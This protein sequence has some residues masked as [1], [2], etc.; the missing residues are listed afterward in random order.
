MSFAMKMSFIQEAASA[1]LY[2]TPSIV[3][4]RDDADL[5]FS[6]DNLGFMGALEDAVTLTAKVVGGEIV[7]VQAG[8][9]A[10]EVFCDNTTCHDTFVWL[11]MEDIEL[12]SF[13]D[14]DFVLEPVAYLSQSF[15]IH[16]FSKSAVNDV[17]D[18]IAVTSTSTELGYLTVVVDPVPNQP[19]INVSNRTVTGEEELPFSMFVLGAWSPDQDGSEIIEVGLSIPATLVDELWIDNEESQL[20]NKSVAREDIILVSRAQSTFETGIHNITILPAA[21]FSGNFDFVIFVRSIEQSTNES[22]STDVTIDVNIHAMQVAVPANLTLVTLN[23]TVEEGQPV[24]LRAIVSNQLVHLHYRLV[25][26]FPIDFISGIGNDEECDKSDAD[27]VCSIVLA[28]AF[29]VSDNF[30]TVVELEIDPNATDLSEILECRTHRER[31][32]L[33]GAEESLTLTVLPVAEAPKFTIDQNDVAIA[34]NALLSVQVTNLA[35]QDLDGSETLAAII[36]C[37]SMNWIYTSTNEGMRR[38][39][40]AGRYPLDLLQA[41]HHSDTSI[42]TV[43]LE[44]RQYFSGTINCS[45]VATAIDV[46]AVGVARDVY[47]V[48]FVTTVTPVPTTPT[49]STTE[50]FFTIKE[51]GT[52]LTDAV[53]ASL[54]DRDGSEVLYLKVDFGMSMVHI[55]AVDWS[56]IGSGAVTLV[57]DGSTVVVTTTALDMVGQLAVQATVGFSGV[58]SWTVAAYSVEKSLGVSYPSNLSV[59]EMKAK[60]TPICHVPAVTMLPTA[61]FTRPL[62]PLELNLTVSTPDRDG[63]EEVQAIV[64]VNVGAVTAILDE[65]GQTL[66]SDNDTIGDALQYHVSPLDGDA[67]YLLNARLFFVPQA[68]FVGI[69]TI[70][71]SAWATEYENG[72]SKSATLSVTVLVLPVDPVMSATATMYSYESAVVHVPFTRFDIGAEVV[73]REHLLLYLPDASQID[74]VYAGLYRADQIVMP[75]NTVGVYSI[76]YEKRGGIM[77]RPKAFAVGFVDIRFVL[78]TVPFELTSGDILFDTVDDGIQVVSVSLLILPVLVDSTKYL[79][80]SASSDVVSSNKPI[81]ARIE[82]SSVFDDRGVSAAGGITPSLLTTQSSPIVTLATTSALVID[83]TSTQDRFFNSFTAD[84]TDVVDVWFLFRFPNGYTDTF[85][86]RVILVTQDVAGQSSS[87]WSLDTTCQLVAEAAGGRLHHGV[88]GGVFVLPDDG[89]IQF[90]LADLGITA[91]L[92]D[93]TRVVLELPQNQ[94]DAVL[95]DNSTMTSVTCDETMRCVYVVADADTVACTG[96]SARCPLLGALTVMPRKYL[97]QTFTFRV[98]VTNREG[99]ADDLFAVSSSFVTSKGYSANVLPVPNTPLMTFDTTNVT[100]VEELPFAFM[101]M[102]AWTPDADGSEVIEV[103]MMMD[104]SLLQSVSVNESTA[105]L[106]STAGSALLIL[107]RDAGVSRIGQTSI[108]MLPRLDFNGGFAVTMFV[109][110]LELSTG[111]I[112]QVNQTVSVT[113]LAMPVVT[114]PRIDVSV[115][116]LTVLEDNPWSVSLRVTPSSGGLRYVF[117]VF[118]PGASVALIEDTNGTA[119]ASQGSQSSPQSLCV[120]PTSSM[121]QPVS[122]T[123]TVTLSMRIWPVKKLSSRF[124]VSI[125]VLALTSDILDALFKSTC[126]QQSRSVDEIL[127][128]RSNRERKSLLSVDKALSLTVSPVAEAPRIVLSS[129]VVIVNENDQV[130]LSIRSITLQ[131]LDGSEQITVALS[132]AALLWDAVTVGN[133][134]S[135]FGPALN[136]TLAQLTAPSLT[137]I[138]NLQVSLRPKMYFSGSISCSVVATAIDV[139]PVGTARDVFQ[140][141]FTATVNAV[142]TTPVLS[143]PRTMFSI[144]EDGLVVTDPVS[145][146][147]VDRDS[148]ESLYVVFDFG[149]SMPVIS[150]AEWL[151][152]SPSDL[153]VT[154]VKTGSA[155]IIYSDSSLDISGRLSV[156]PVVGFSGNVAWQASAFSAEKSFKLSPAALWTTATLAGKSSAVV[157]SFSVVVSPICHTPQVL[158]TPTSAVSRPLVPILMNISALTADQDG[159]EVLS[160]QVV[161]N[162]TAVLQ[163]RDYNDGSVWVPS[164]TVQLVDTFMVGPAADKPVFTIQRWLSIVPRAEFTGYFTVNLTV[165]SLE[166]ETGE[167]KSASVALLVMIL[168]ADPVVSS[169]AIVNV[170]ENEMVR[171]PFSR[172]D[173]NQEVMTRDNVLLY[174][175]DGSMVSD[176][177]VGFSRLQ[178]SS[179][180]LGS[181]RFYSIPYE[182]RNLVFLRP[183]QYFVGFLEVYFILST[184]KIPIQTDSTYADVNDGIT[185]QSSQV[186]TIPVPVEVVTESEQ[187]RSFKCS[188]ERTIEVLDFQN[189]SIPL[190]NLSFVGSL[191]DISFIR[192]EYAP[193]AVDGVDVPSVT[194]RARGA[195]PNYDADVYDT[196]APADFSCVQG[197]NPVCSFDGQINVMPHLYLAQSFKMTVK[198]WFLMPA[199]D[200]SFVTNSQALA[201]QHYA[202][203][204]KPA[205]NPPYLVLSALVINGAE[206]TESSFLIAS[207]GTPDQ[208]GSE[209]IE[210]SIRF[211][212]SMVR[213]VKL[214]SQQLPIR[215][216]ENSTTGM[217]VVVG[218]DAMQYVVNALSIAVTPSLNLG[219]ISFQMTVQVVS[220]ETSTRETAQFSQVITLNIGAVADPPVLIVA[221]RDVTTAQGSMTQISVNS[222]ELVDKDGSETLVVGIQ[223]AGGLFDRV[224]VNMNNSLLDGS[225]GIFVATPPSQLPFT[226]EVYPNKG[227]FGTTTFQ[228]FATSA[229]LTNGNQSTSVVTVQLTVSPLADVPVIEVEDTRGRL[230]DWVSVGIVNITVPN[231]LKEAATQLSAYLVPD[232]TRAQFQMMQ[233]STIVQPQTRVAVSSSPSYEVLMDYE[234][235]PVAVK[236][237]DPVG[238]LTFDLVVIT[239]VQSSNSTS[240]S[241]ESLTVSFAGVVFTPPSLSLTEGDVRQLSLQMLSAPLGTV[242]LSLTSSIPAK[243]VP[244]PPEVTFSM[245]DWSTT[246][247]VRIT[248]L[249]NYLDDPDASGVLTSVVTST[250][251]MYSGMNL[252]AFPIVVVNDDFSNV[253]AFQGVVTSRP[254]VV[255]SERRILSDVFSL[256][257]TAEPTADVT[258]SL[259]LASGDFLVV[260]PLQLFFTSTNWNVSQLVS[261]SADDNGIQDGGGRVGHIGYAVSSVDPLY[262]GKAIPPLDVNIVETSDTTPPPKMTSA[263][264]LN[265]AVGLTVTFDRPIDRSDFAATTFPCDLIFDVPWR[266]FGNGTSCTWLAGDSSIRFVFGRGATV[267]PGQGLGLKGGLLRASPTAQLRSAQTSVAITPPDIIPQPSAMVSGATSLGVCDDLSLDGSSSTGSGG[268]T[269]SFRWFLVGSINATTSVAD[270]QAMLL[271]AIVTNNATMVIPG[272]ML[273]PDATYQFVLQASNFF[274][275]ASNSSV[276][277]VKKSGLPLPVVSIKGGNVQQ[278]YRAKEL[279]ISA[280]ADNPRCSVPSADGGGASSVDMSFRWSQ[281]QGDLT[282]QA[283][284]STS[285]NPRVLKLPPRTLNIGTKYIFQIFVSMVSNP[286]IANSATVELTVL[287]SPLSAQVLG[288]DREWGTTQNLTLDATQSLD[289]D[290]SSVPMQYQWNCSQFNNETLQY[291]LGCLTVNSTKLVLEPIGKTL[292]PASTMMAD[293][294]YKFSAIVSKDSRTSSTS[295]K[296]LFK[297]GSIPQVS[298]A[299]LSSSRV[300]VN[301][302]VMLQAS[303][304]SSVPLQKTLWSLVGSNAGLEA[305]LFAVPAS[306]TTMVLAQNAMIPGATY[307]FQ[308]VAVDVNGQNSTAS[309]IVTANSPPTSGELVVSPTSGIALADKFVLSSLN[310]V[311]ED[312]P[313]KY[314]YKFIKGVE[315]DESVEIVMGAASLEP[316]LSTIFPVGAGEASIITVVAYVMDALGA[317]T[318]TTAEIT[319]KEQNFANSTARDAYL[320]SMA[321]DVLAQAMTGDPSKVM[322]VISALGD[323]IA[324]KEAISTVAPNDV[325]KACPKANNAQCN[326]KGNCL[327]SPV[328]CPATDV[329]CVVTCQ[330]LPNYFGDNCALTKAQYEAKQAAVSGL[331]GA[332]A[333]SVKSIDI[334]DASA[335]EQSAGGILSLTKSAS[336]LGESAQNAAVNFVDNI[337]SAQL[338][339]SAA[340]AVGNT[341]SNILDAEVNRAV[342]AIAPAAASHA[343]RLTANDSATTSNTSTSSTNATDEKAMQ[344]LAAVEKIKGTIGKFGTALLASSLP[345]EKPVSFVSKNMKLVGARD[346]PT[347]FEGKQVKVPLTAAEIAANFTPPSCTIPM[348][349]AQHIQAQRRRRRLTTGDETDEEAPVDVHSA[350]FVK[351]PYAFSGATVNSP[352]MSIKVHEGEGEVPVNDLAQPFQIFMRNTGKVTAIV[353]GVN[354]TTHSDVVN[355][356]TLRVS[357]YL[358]C[359]GFDQPV[360][361]EVCNGTSGYRSRA[362]CP[363]RTP[364]CQYWNTTLNNWDTTGCTA[365]GTTPDG[366]YTICNCTHLTDFA[367]DVEQ[368]LAVLSAHFDRVMTHTVTAADIKRNVALII[369]MALFFILFIIAFFYVSR[370]DHADRIRQMREN[371][372]RIQEAQKVNV[373][374]LF[375]EPEYVRAVGYRAKA[376]AV[377]ASFWKGLKEE[378]KLLSIAFKYDEYFSRPQR[379]TIIFTVIMSHMFTN[380]LLYANKTTGAKTV[381]GAVVCGVVS[382]LCMMPVT[383]AFV[384]MFKKAGRKRNYVLRY[385]VE[386]SEGNVAHVE[387]DAYGK[388]REYSPIEVCKMDM[389]AIA[390]CVEVRRIKRFVRDFKKRGLD[391]RVG[392]VCRGL[393]LAI[394]NRD[395]DEDPPVTNAHDEDV[396]Q[397]VLHQI[398]TRI[399][400]RAKSLQ[401]GGAAA[402]AARRSKSVFGLFGARS[403]R[404]LMEMLER[405]GGESMISSMLAFDPLSLTASTGAKIAEVCEALSQYANEEEEYDSDDDDDDDVDVVLT[406]KD[407]LDKCHECCKL[408]Q[409]S[410]RAMMHKAKVELQRTETQLRK[411]EHAIGSQFDR[412]LTELGVITEALAIG[413]RRKTTDTINGVATMAREARRKTSRRMRKQSEVPKVD[414]RLSVTI[415]KEKKSVLNANRAVLKEKRNAVKRAQ[416]MT[417]DEQKRLRKEADRELAKVTMGLV[418]IAKMKKKLQLYLEAKEKQRIDALPW[419]ERHA[420]ELEK[421]QLKKIKGVSRLLYNQFLRRQP[422]KVAKPIFP[423]WVVYIS[424]AISIV[425]CCWSAYFVMMFGFSLTEENTSTLWIGSLLAGLAMTH[426]VS[427]PAKIF[428]KMGLMP[429]VA[430]GILADTGVFDLGSEGLALAAAAALGS[431]GVAQVIAKNDSRLK[432]KMRT[433]KLVPTTEEEALEAIAGRLPA[434]VEE[435][436]DPV[437]PPV[438]DDLAKLEVEK[439]KEEI[440]PKLAIH[441]R[442]PPIP[443][444]V[445]SPATSPRPI[446]HLPSRKPISIPPVG[447]KRS[448]RVAVEVT[449]PVGE[450]P[451]PVHE[452]PPLPVTQVAMPEVPPLPV[453]QL[454]EQPR[455]VDKSVVVEKP[456]T[457]EKPLR[458]PRV[459]RPARS[460]VYE[461]PAAP[462]AQPEMTVCECGDTMPADTLLEH[463]TETC[464][465][466]L[467]QCRAGCGMFVQARSL[468]GHELSQCRLV[469]CSCGKM[470][471]TKSLEQHQQRECRNK[472]ISC[473]LECGQRFP[474]HHR[475]RHERHECAMRKTSCPQ[476]GISCM[477]MDMERHMKGECQLHQASTKVTSAMRAFAPQPQVQPVEAQPVQAPQPEATQAPVVSQPKL[478]VSAI[479]G[480]MRPPAGPPP[481]RALPRAPP[482]PAGP[483]RGPLAGSAVG[484]AASAA[485]A[486]HDLPTTPDKEKVQK[487]RERLLARKHPNLQVSTTSEAEEKA[488]APTGADAAQVVPTEEKPVTPSVAAARPSGGAV[489]PTNAGA[490]T[491]RFMM[492]PPRGQP[493]VRPPVRPVMRPPPMAPSGT[494]PS[495]AQA[496]IAMSPSSRRS[497]LMRGPGLAVIAPKAP[498]VESPREDEV[499]AAALARPS[500]TIEVE[501]TSAAPEAAAVPGVQV[502]RSPMRASMRGPPQAAVNPESKPRV[503]PPTSVAENVNEIAKL[504]FDNETAEEDKI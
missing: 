269:L 11:E 370:W 55:A 102:G 39:G 315:T 300:N 173:I 151:S 84:T 342:P 56:P 109:R 131:D 236:T 431:A 349:F 53:T 478:N 388:P 60:V 44:P 296:Y 292:I 483:P 140:V 43:T 434:E 57:R 155:L 272:G 504:L 158:L 336:L 399:V 401:E 232:N 79:T 257:L 23:S 329:S 365:V 385:Q 264:F 143:T 189:F 8:D 372:L 433:K 499:M 157:L 204:V 15:E 187:I 68:E 142:A 473:R 424:Y 230:G 445:R 287:P 502:P 435:P 221:Q 126:F 125:S 74:G 406:L 135:S 352:V 104:F 318:R 123:S 337:V 174:I 371:R 181:A 210:I 363:T 180:T 333:T 285:T 305:S 24:M 447:P 302:R 497:L 133:S 491:G 281:L 129:S 290:N 456:L 153:T 368:S 188:A 303:V 65:F 256:M 190:M 224:T 280:T 429:V 48:P 127:K 328:N 136:Y 441:M 152:Q 214:G 415:K 226:F 209:V 148:S 116:Q 418:G 144:L 408:Q 163:V 218:R 34:E 196:F 178:P 420:F 99:S 414:K 286:K 21:D 91:S 38:T 10:A 202:V 383:I 316:S 229:E 345:G 168:P 487:M 42:H 306:R 2:T 248:A 367:T 113:V 149:S 165:T 496:T 166:K 501:S 362:T 324:G 374:S 432:R 175:A 263:K 67:V 32:S 358:H 330:C 493:P 498:V 121:T 454:V 66:V 238:S 114:K 20:S 453:A 304:V 26:F 183:R 353:D 259:V 156:R 37:S 265:T 270:I 83:Q 6:V 482:R 425:M 480:P 468:S 206:D 428:F 240:R 410:A 222:L 377:L 438:F 451:L 398:K 208:D 81:L 321:Q 52:V 176:V 275:A 294:M 317:Q 220:M 458:P 396:L 139:S 261:V 474:A 421:K 283:A 314:V 394:N 467:V 69:F 94:I 215:P 479:R 311:D 245:D 427:D 211:D 320:T 389:E 332:M 326:A 62:V 93:I 198:I 162:N 267:A 284:T 47:S 494:I 464:S 225:S 356:R 262:N 490:P 80:A 400:D 288:G 440:V 309:I 78:A 452:V 217:V 239:F 77:I 98:I 295:V 73:R 35:L 381:G 231:K 92:A 192:V 278:V 90:T 373:R 359:S 364:K 455:A 341:V 250:D 417:R 96:A 465:H 246:R 31:K 271:R 213:S 380:A 351:N 299:P 282:D 422:A 124:G 472:L 254:N 184:V 128:C 489:T 402:S 343:R 59:V 82:A 19:Y 191:A 105:T 297:S 242:T 393:F 49:L 266:V 327:R 51:D 138:E 16:F 233:G 110:S 88:P 291:D 244:T 29:N 146:S 253:L 14:S 485:P 86:S 355:C 407:W 350:V 150:A 103:G 237:T 387:T 397:P 108:R 442:G 423:E 503:V 354:I 255:V 71:I 169:T 403:S 386:D 25:A 197:G 249:N 379:L 247:L 28:S 322:N 481:T 45:I 228:V 331:I 361:I 409:S 475:E 118:Y 462:R 3:H 276:I 500:P 36:E 323:M 120:L 279:M 216:V 54:V 412:R 112:N 319:V 476:C 58:L 30:S 495:V 344:R 492:M 308:L 450:V 76:P 334:S 274:L 241:N 277:T 167:Q 205:P 460:V 122:A 22:V 207:A 193:R 41:K 384:I 172:L 212:V 235:D 223:A 234:S 227:Y 395:M 101:L 338:S 463:K 201:V 134:S 325:T 137:S 416:K 293:K 100:G 185:M 382:S 199:A 106:P 130:N 448:P 459:A 446:V 141:P 17:R 348:G 470:V 411:L 466:R 7:H 457:W 378:H 461:P 50:T 40:S 357:V 439:P 203:T 12:I 391:S 177:F 486:A 335:V 9:F 64:S 119:C 307:Q 243:A 72:E 430:A 95:L 260:S 413:T 471:L 375:Q 132:C 70:R 477:A 346:T 369:T 117:A 252:N 200:D 484:A 194:T 340:T 392:Q 405:N 360:K 85:S 443:K 164:Q 313:L 33:V 390:K 63:S 13:N 449:P 145:A 195:N 115:D 436:S 437:K 111:A 258:V 171:L 61:G 87:V 310:W 159:S 444:P 161:V 75:S 301:D 488:P 376:K 46:S 469:M 268:R 107:A 312:L 347:H 366:A 298:I 1:V 182:S 186:A 339:P 89:S 154:V 273:E 170:K 4:I 289:P 97:A 419:H 426:I 27:G 219:G 147:L 18:E 251:Q 179:A 160:A 5:R 404:Q